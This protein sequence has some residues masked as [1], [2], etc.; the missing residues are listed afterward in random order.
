MFLKGNRRYG[1]SRCNIW[2][3]L[4][5]LSYNIYPGYYHLPSNKY[6]LKYEVKFLS[7]NKSTVSTRYIVLVGVGSFLL[8]I[9]FAFISETLSQ[10]FNNLILSFFFLI[11]II[12]INIIS[13]ILGTAVTAATEPPFH[14]K[15]AKR[16]SGSQQS[17]L[18][19]RNADRVAN[20]TNDV[21]GDIA[22]TLSGALG[23]S[24]AVQV[25]LRL[26]GFDQL[27]LN[28]FLTALI[29]AL[30]VGGKAAGKKIAL[31]HS[32]KVVF[33][34]GRLLALVERITGFSFFKA[35]SGAKRKERM[36]R[37]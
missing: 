23:I 37:P 17:I 20:I 15:A 28:V 19:I 24:L 22:G 2:E 36:S 32:N 18:L 6:F 29:A 1:D 8:A 14:A 10:K 26:H 7:S 11:I 31:T 33:L 34:A 12:L 30:T 27:M 35:K 9:I 4:L 25:F 16:V 13:D 21:I 5:D 3:N